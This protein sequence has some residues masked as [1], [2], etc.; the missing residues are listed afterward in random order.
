MWRH[1]CELAESRPHAGPARPPGANPASPPLPPAPVFSG[2]LPRRRSSS[3]QAPRAPAAAAGSGMENV[4]NIKMP[5]GGPAAGR[6][7]RVLLLGGAAVYG[8]TN[9]LFNVEGGHRWAAGASGWA[10]LGGWHP[11]T[12]RGSRGRMSTMR[13][14][15]PGPRNGRARCGGDRQLMCTARRGA[16][17]PPSSP[18]APLACRRRC[19][20]PPLP[21]CPTSPAAC[22]AGPQGDRVQPAW[23]HQG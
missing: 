16:G 5:A 1:C 4:K 2:L 18:E 3:G 6:L 15:S 19:L 22:P 17:A 23:R 9:C 7:A 8:L 10:D 20:P 21:S 12:R 14:A 11:A 13:A